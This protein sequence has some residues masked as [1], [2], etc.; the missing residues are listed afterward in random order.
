MLR[1]R[2]IPCLL[3]RAGGLVKT[4]G[5]ANPSYVGDPINAVRIFN[6]KE[7]DE[8]I[9]LD[10][11]A[12]RQGR[13][14]DFEQIASIVDEAFMP[15]AY[16]GGV[17][18]LAHAERL[19]TLGVEKIVINTAALDSWDVV[20]AIADRFGSQAM[21]VAVDVRKDWRGRYRVYHAASGVTTDVLALDHARA[22]VAAGA[23]ELFINDVTRDGTG[24]GYDLELIRSIAASVDVPLIAC[25]GAGTLEHLRA[26][27]DAGASATAAGSLFVYVGRHRAVMINYPQ[28]SV[29]QRLFE[30]G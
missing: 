20:R 23:G 24:N 10:I 17:A 18:S 25:G 13:A 21:A 9:L 5:F 11:E 4:I 15:I 30:H 22:A 19:V 12:S 14:P 6:E 26:A 1:A 29:L 7:V 2:V 3:L 28:Y 16:G 27:V 8:L